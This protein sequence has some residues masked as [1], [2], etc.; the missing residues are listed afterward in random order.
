MYPYNSYKKYSIVGIALLWAMPFFAQQCVW[1]LNGAVTDADTQEPLFAANIYIREAAVGAVTDE[2]G[3]F[4]ISN[5]CNGDYHLIVSHIGCETKQIFVHIHEDTTIQVN[6]AHNSTLLESVV[7]TER[8]T[9]QSTQNTQLIGQQTISESAYQNLATLLTNISG[10]SSIKSGGG[11]AKPIV[12][13]LYGNRL[14][15]L[16]NGVAQSGQQ[17][18]NDHSPEIDPQVAQKIRVIKGVSALAYPGANLGSVILIE[19]ERVQ[20]EPHLHGKISYFHETNGRANGLNT[21]WQRNMG[22]WAW[23]VNGTLKQNGDRRT[24]DYFLRNTGVREANVAVQLEQTSSERWRNELY[25]SSFNSELGILRGSHVGNLTDLRFAFDRDVPFFTE[26]SFRAGIEP[27]K[28]RVNHQLLKLNSRYFINENEWI[29]LKAATQLNLRKEF[30]VRRSGRSDIPVLSLRQWTQFLEAQY[31]REFNNDSRWTSGLQTNITNNLNNPETGILP[32]IPDY[33]AYE[34]AVYTILKK[35]VGQWNWEG[36]ARYEY[37]QQNAVVISRNSSRDILRFNES[38]QNLS[39]SSGLQYRMTP[40][41]S[42]QFNVGY[43]ERSPAVNELYSSGLHQGVSGIEEGNAE[44]NSEHAF[45][46]TL[47]LSG[48]LNA[49][50]SF[51][52]LGHYQYIQDYI[53]LQPQDEL[54][55]TIR[56]AFPVFGYEQTNARIYGLDLSM[57]YQLTDSWRIKGIYSFLRGDDR[58]Q[59]LPLINMPANNLSHTLSYEKSKW[60]GIENI[61]LEVGSRYVF[62]QNHLLIEQD[63]VAPPAA[64]HLLNVHIAGDVK[65]RKQRF[66][67]FMKVDNALN[68]RYRDYLNRQ[69]YFADDWGRNVIFGASFEL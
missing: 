45:K 50:F 31:E 19:P 62:Q 51:E 6:L 33:I 60:K 58:S 14:T 13:G 1:Q 32:L 49:R 56:G 57:H 24:A 9:E 23:K 22:N 20:N 10:V 21:Q 44:L 55:L 2:Q 63:F 52:A 27:P 46:S 42:W 26:E 59:Q 48:N 11:I 47:S 43:A 54:R 30:D 25:F 53:F 29:E 67:L 36:G 7:V 66:R 65:W 5:L 64:Y 8:Q 12:H 40:T 28:Q 61:Q 37:V 4:E 39:A 18:G 69:R 35:Q 17:W 38:Y 68:V 34:S 15:V 3:R 41:L 16:N